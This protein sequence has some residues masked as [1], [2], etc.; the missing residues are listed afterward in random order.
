MCTTAVFSNRESERE[1]LKER[2]SGKNFKGF[3]WPDEPKDIE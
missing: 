2:I 1:I 3:L